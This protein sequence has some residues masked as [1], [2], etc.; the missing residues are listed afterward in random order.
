L[1]FAFA[2]LILWVASAGGTHP[3]GV[4][5]A[6][7]AKALPGRIQE[8][9]EPQSAPLPAR[10]VKS[11]GSKLKPTKGPSPDP[12]MVETPKNQDSGTINWGREATLDESVWVAQNPFFKDAS[13]YNKSGAK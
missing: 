11:A 7:K 10:R 8:A 6:E 12:L 4:P 5:A 13:P 1:T 3:A 9:K 2:S